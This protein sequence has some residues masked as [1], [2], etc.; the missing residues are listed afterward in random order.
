M[1]MKE[2]EENQRRLSDVCQ[3]AFCSRRRRRC[4]IRSIGC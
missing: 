1:R 3:F 4:R 2:E